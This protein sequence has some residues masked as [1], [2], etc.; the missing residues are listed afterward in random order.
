L[1]WQFLST[2]FGDTMREPI[3]ISVP[4]R[5]TMEEEEAFNEIERRS[6]VKQELI[7]SPSKEAKLQAEVLAL[8]IAVK[9][10]TERVERLEK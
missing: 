3:G 5:I 2:I 6:K 1:R 9:A 7:K 10:L 4:M 8:T